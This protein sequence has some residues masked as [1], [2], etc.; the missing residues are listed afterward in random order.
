MFCLAWRGA[1]T[2]TSSGNIATAGNNA[3]GIYAFGHGAG[4]VTVTSTGNI[5][6]AGSGSYGIIAGSHGPITVTI[7]SG[8]VSAARGSAPASISL[9]APPT[10]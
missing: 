4:A 2:V 6:T 10:R 9:A 7:K 5:T 3:N 1:V 8:T